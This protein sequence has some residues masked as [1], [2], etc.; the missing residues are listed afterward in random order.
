V[1]SDY[2]RAMGITVT[3]GRGFTPQDNATAPP[4]VVIN[5]TMA[6]RYWPGNSP[7]GKRVMLSGPEVWREVVGV[8][9]DVRHWGLDA[10]VNPELYFPHVQ[11]PF[12]SAMTF[13]VRTG[14]EPALLAAAAREQVRSIDPNLPVSAL[15]TMDEVAALSMTSRR[16]G[17]LLLTIFGLLALTLAA[18]GIYGVMSQ[19]VAVRRAEI[20]IRMTL[21]ARPAAVMR[22]V[23]KE[24]LLQAAAGLAIGVAGGVLAMRTFRAMLFEVDPA[25]PV[26]IAVVAVLLLATA[27]L[28]CIV[29]AHRAMRLDPVQAMRN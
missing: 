14:A 22:L 28:A 29:P 10:P 5:D 27:T 19:L 15:R 3:A 4:V 1:T 9:A 8:V 23:L 21:G 7:V 17:M 24:G 6:R 11:L 12:S 25:D 16:S 13:V 20:G 26:T 2:F 18:A